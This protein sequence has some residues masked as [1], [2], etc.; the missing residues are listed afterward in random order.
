MGKLSTTIQVEKPADG[1]RPPGLRVRWQP[2]QPTVAQFEILRGPALQR[3]GQPSK[4]TAVQAAQP[5]ILRTRP[6]VRA[7]NYSQAQIDSFIVKPDHT[8]SGW[9]YSDDDNYADAHFSVTNR[10]ARE[11]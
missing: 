11:Q 7:D 4:L 9:I 8:W 5:L 6:T 1:K 2:D 10:T 3:R